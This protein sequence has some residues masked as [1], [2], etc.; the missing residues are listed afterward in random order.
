MKRF[1]FLSF[2]ALSLSALT[3]CNQENDD[4][5]H[6]RAECKYDT[7]TLSWNDDAG[8]GQSYKELLK[9]YERT[10]EVRNGGDDAST[11]IRPAILL[12]FGV[13]TEQP[14][15]RYENSEGGCPDYVEL[16]AQ[17][18]LAEDEQRFWEQ[19]FAFRLDELTDEDLSA[20]AYIED[21]SEYEE[22]ERIETMPDL[23][24]NE[25]L[26]HVVSEV[27]LQSNG[28]LTLEFLLDIEGTQGSG[29]DS[30][31]SNYLAP[32]FELVVFGNQLHD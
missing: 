13:D 14:P 27:T 25:T 16:P 21:A 26:L 18:A 32:W 24:D 17:M 5:N 11:D 28:G 31:V 20:T 29:K 3:A 9:P 6:E 12:T 8:E 19:S 2:A 1:V 15:V 4:L 10:R 7:H 30:A 23:E 22:L